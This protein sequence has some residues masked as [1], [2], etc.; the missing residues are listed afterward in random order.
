M[1]SRTTLPVSRCSY[2]SVMV[3]SAARKVSSSASP[4]ALTRPS[5]PSKRLAMKPAARLAML[6]NLPTRS[7]LTRSMKSSALKSMSSLRP[8]SLAAM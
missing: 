3:G 5:R 8:D 2:Q 7:L 6:M 1:T 4:S